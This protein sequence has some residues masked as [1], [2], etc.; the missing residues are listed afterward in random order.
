MNRQILTLPIISAQTFQVIVT[1]LAGFPFVARNLVLAIG[2]Y[3]R[4]VSI[5]H[6][7]QVNSNKIVNNIKLCLGT[8]WTISFILMTITIVTDTTEYYFSVVGALPG[9]PNKQTSI[10]FGG[11]LTITFITSAICL[12]KALRELMRMQSRSAVPA[13]DDLIAKRSTQYITIVSITHHFSYIPTILSVV[14]NS[15]DDIPNSTGD[16]VRW[17]FFYYMVMYSIF[18]VVLYFIMTPGYRIHVMNLLMFK[19]ST[20]RPN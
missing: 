7:Y 16:L 20:V 1:I 9:E 8:A 17:I 6:P 4:Y 2:C 3:E 19:K 13:Q 11:S 5:C 14:C 15:V 10:V 12:S 18:N